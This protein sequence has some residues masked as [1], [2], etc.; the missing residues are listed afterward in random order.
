MDYVG[1]LTF[2]AVRCLI[3]AVV[4]VPCVFLLDALG[5][6]QDR[7]GEGGPA[8]T[9]AAGKTAYSPAA[10]RADG[11]AREAGKSGGPGQLRRWADPQLWKG[12]V[13]CGVFLCL[14]SNLQ[15]IGIVYTSVGKAGFITAMYIVIVPL[16]GIL[17]GRRS[18]WKIWVSV[19]LAVVGLYL[20]C[21]SGKLEINKGDVLMLGCAL[22][23]SFQIMA[24]DHYA[25]K[26]DNV[27]LSCL[28]FCVCG[29]ISAVLMFVFENP[30]ITSI[31]AAKLPILYAGVRSCGVAYT[32][33]I[34][35]QKGLDPAVASLI[36]S[37]ESVVSA[38]GGWLILRQGLSGR[39]IAGCAIMFAAVLLAQR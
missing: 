6:G 34:I 10:G 27:R 3:G 31:L 14:A 4:L 35:G 30:R 19:L 28:E 23:F 36:M 9:S 11:A 32:F 7:S 22:C 21:M 8:G 29:L 20:L 38:L 39:E 25:D 33:Q 1:P 16:I 12:G 13:I 18:N 15:Q 17:A 2:N 26:V 37:L 5:A 24:V